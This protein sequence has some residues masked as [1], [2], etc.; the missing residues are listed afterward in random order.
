MAASE[1]GR[2]SRAHDDAVTAPLRPRA[3]DP[4]TWA[5][6]SAE[7]AAGRA[8]RNSGGSPGAELRRPGHSDRRS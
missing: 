6:L 2:P 5:R 7:A 3:W 4:R 1:P 8:A